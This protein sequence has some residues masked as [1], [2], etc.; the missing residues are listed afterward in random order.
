MGDSEKPWDLKVT[1]FTK[2]IYLSAGPQKLIDRGR[3]P[4]SWLGKLR[5]AGFLSH[6]PRGFPLNHWHSGKATSF[7]SQ[8]SKEDKYLK[9]DG[10]G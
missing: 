7:S 3:I 5:A 9:P 10:F 2:R 1:L 6:D 8:Q 4:T